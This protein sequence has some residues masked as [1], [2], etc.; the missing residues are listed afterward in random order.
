[1]SIKEPDGSQTIAF[2]TS[3]RRWTYEELAF[4]NPV[5]KLEI[6]VTR[7]TDE[8]FSLA[9]DDIELTPCPGK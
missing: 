7:S 4:I 6:E 9:F 1:M 8:D 2:W 5:R 3:A